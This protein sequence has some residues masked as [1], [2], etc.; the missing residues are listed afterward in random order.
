MTT[1]DC[2]RGRPLP[3]TSREGSSCDG[4]KVCAHNGGLVILDERF[5]GL[6]AKRRHPLATIPTHS[7]RHSTRPRR[8]ARENL[9]HL[10]QP[11]LCFLSRRPC[12]ALKGLLG[13]PERLCKGGLRHIE[14]SRHRVHVNMAA[15]QRKPCDRPELPIDSERFAYRRF[16]LTGNAP[17][18]D[19][20]LL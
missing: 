12:G 14:L 16:P 18:T 19:C 7:L 13:E 4:V 17:R 3:Q 11:L 1:S 20:A 8:H 15:A 6:I 10:A 9:Q 2:G 5:G